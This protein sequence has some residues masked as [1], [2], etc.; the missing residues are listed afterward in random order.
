MLTGNG[1]TA[2]FLLSALG[3][4]SPDTALLVAQLLAI[5]LLG[6]FGGRIGWSVRGRVQSLIVGAVLTGG[7][8]LLITSLKFFA[9]L[10]QQVM[11]W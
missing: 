1:P 8:G 10:S 4:F 7:L 3:V 6:W 5:G 2:A 9:S 11:R